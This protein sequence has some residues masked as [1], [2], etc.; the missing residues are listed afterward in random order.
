MLLFHLLLHP[1]MLEP[2]DSSMRVPYLPV[3]F[4]VPFACRIA[5][6]ES[7]R[8]LRHTPRH[9]SQYTFLVLDVVDAALQKPCIKRRVYSDWSS[10]YPEDIVWNGQQHL[11]KSDNSPYP[12]QKPDDY[13]LSIQ[14]DIDQLNL[15]ENHNNAGILSQAANYDKGLPGLLQ[16]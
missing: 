2:P 11:P 14:D 6:L 4:Q 8:I 5:V 13:L 3:S 15:R 9:T 1:P 10:F 16:L 12:E 7:H